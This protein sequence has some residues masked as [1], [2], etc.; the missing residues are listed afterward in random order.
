MVGSSLKKEDFSY[1]GYFTNKNYRV[2]Y[3]IHQFYLSYDSIFT[4]NNEKG[5]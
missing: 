5:F 3:F 1:T 2:A 4:K